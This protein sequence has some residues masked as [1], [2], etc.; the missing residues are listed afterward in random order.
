[1]IREVGVGHHLKVFPDRSALWGA[2]IEN[3]EFK[4]FV[5]VVF[6]EYISLVHQCCKGREKYANFQVKWMDFVRTVLHEPI[7]KHH[8]SKQWSVVEEKMDVVPSKSARNAVMSSVMRAVLNYSQQRLV[9]VKEGE[10]LLLEYEQDDDC[11]IEAGMEIKTSWRT[12]VR[13][14]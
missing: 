7:D 10:T 3:Q 5:S 4:T 6:R 13:R 9:A 14:M 11:F 2:C 8:A 1:M 12:V